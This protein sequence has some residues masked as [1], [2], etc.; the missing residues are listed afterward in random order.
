MQ[1][2]LY[3]ALIFFLAIGFSA[4]AQQ[5]DN[6]IPIKLKEVPVSPSLLPY[7][8]PLEDEKPA[9]PAADTVSSFQGSSEPGDLGK[10]MMQHIARIYRVHVQAIEAQLNEDPLQAETHITSALNELQ[11][12]LDKYPEIQSNQ[13]F[14]ELYRSVMTEYRK[15]YGVTEEET[16]V[17]GEIFAIQ[18]ELFSDDNDWMEE[19]YSLPENLPTTRTNV[20]LV[21]NDKVNKHLMY[22]SM[23]R[24]EVMEGWL[25]RSERYF[26]MMEEIF[27]EEDVPT[28]LIRL[29]MVESGLNPKAKSWASAVGMWQFIRA[30]GSM[31]GLEVNWWVDERRD[32]EKAT[33]AAARHLK[34]LYEVWGD[35]HLAL[36]GYN[37]SPRGLNHAIRRAGGARDYWKAWSY[38]PRETRNYVPSYIAA[39]MIEMNPEA[40][41]FEKRYNEDRYRYDVYR[42]APLM[43]LDALA[44]AAG[45]TLEKLKEYN[46]ELLRWATPPGDEYPLK[47]PAGLRQRFATNYEDIPKDE[48]GSN[49]AMHTVTRGESLGRIARKY[50]TS[51]RALYETN[52]NL[53]S[54]IYPGQKIV[55]PLAPGS[56]NKI[57]ANRPSNESE[58]KSKASSQT[59][60]SVSKSSNRAKIRYKVK[61]GDTVGHI[62]EWFDVSSS[63][64]RGWNNTSN[65]IN[66]GE[67]LDVYVAKSKESFYEKVSEMSFSGKQAMEQKQRSGEDVT[68]AYLTSRT[69]SDGEYTVRPN[70]TLIDIANMHGVSVSQIRRLN[71]L[72][73]SRIYVGQKLKIN[74][75]K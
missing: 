37:I 72:N 13:R 48:R 67:Y 58:S 64:I 57:A 65:N 51:V 36:A 68:E 28:E 41:G 38:L 23:K 11:E 63:Q 54:T 4:T 9:T 34:D 1:Q 73:G 3:S 7:N 42:V 56:T 43:P 5:A 59:N 75:S 24:P 27:R 17:E 12:L 19:S 16:E 62:A 47:L 44:E 40:F 70:D 14:N 25:K 46:P 53:S 71:R 49:I 33:R 15:F 52:E 20:P 30:T 22:F 45:I 32:P 2:K 29:S 60:S 61:K 39:T 31:Y 8:N 10:D 26:P 55:V 35:W 66:P 21:Q 18:K 6:T 50:G 69:S 74:S